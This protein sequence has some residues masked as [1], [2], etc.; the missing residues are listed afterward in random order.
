MMRL[1]KYISKKHPKYIWK[2]KNMCIGNCYQWLKQV[3][4]SWIKFARY[5][6]IKQQ[7]DQADFEK[8]N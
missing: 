5:E 4:S 8:K 6:K 1:E 3:N 7:K 2:L